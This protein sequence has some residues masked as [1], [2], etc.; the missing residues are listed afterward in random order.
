M[1]R[2]SLV[3]AMIAPIQRAVPTLTA[4]T[5]TEKSLAAAEQVV[6]PVVGTMEGTPIGGR[7]EIY[8]TNTGMTY[9]V[10][11][12]DSTSHDNAKSSTSRA[13]AELAGRVVQQLDD[14]PAGYLTAPTGWEVLTDDTLPK[15]A[16][17]YGYFPAGGRSFGWFMAYRVDIHNLEDALS[18]SVVD[19]AHV[20]GSGS[21]RSPAADSG[22]VATVDGFFDALTATMDGV[23]DELCKCP[24]Y[25][26]AKALATD[27]AS[28][29][30]SSAL[31][32]TAGKKMTRELVDMLAEMNREPGA[33]LPEVKRRRAQWWSGF[34]RRFDGCVAALRGR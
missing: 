20:V 24:N 25:A 29:G 18:A 22:E 15:G 27:S 34:Q 4:G 9:L 11:L 17:A 8:L 13:L 5:E 23:L 28:R 26:C 3:K 21:G 10:V 30:F 2:A 33:F 14:V 6:V 12:S 7:G 1:L 32:Y 16:V 31:S 19:D